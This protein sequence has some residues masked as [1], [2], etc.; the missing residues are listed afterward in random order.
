MIECLE[1]ACSWFSGPV[2]DSVGKVHG[3]QKK[4]SGLLA[5]LWNLAIAGGP[6]FKINKNNRKE[7]SFDCCQARAAFLQTVNNFARLFGVSC[8]VGFDITFVVESAV[9]LRIDRIFSFRAVTV[10]DMAKHSAAFHR[11]GPLFSVL[12]AHVPFRP[13]SALCTPRNWL[14]VSKCK[15]SREQCK[16]WNGKRF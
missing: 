16:P 12:Q 6:C 14:T 7:S 8:I 1:F 15:L 9:S 13:R 5:N 3:A 10:D 4:W 11:V 2:G